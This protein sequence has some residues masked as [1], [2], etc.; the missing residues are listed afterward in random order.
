MARIRQVLSDTGFE[1]RRLY[2]ELTES[3][4]LHDEAVLALGRALEL[5]VVAQGVKTPAQAAL[6]RAMGCQ[7]AQGHLF[8]R[9]VSA[10]ELSALLTGE[11]LR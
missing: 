7:R 9:G 1:P 4:L 6:L 10:A 3:A 8:S 11:L 5:Q 2:V